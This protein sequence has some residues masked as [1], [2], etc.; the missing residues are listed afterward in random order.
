MLRAANKVRVFAAADLD[1][2]NVQERRETLGKSKMIS[3]W[4]LIAPLYL[5][6]IT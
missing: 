4:L 2:L 3:H 5:I 6:A 1:P